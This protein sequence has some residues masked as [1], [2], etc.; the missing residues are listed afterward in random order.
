MLVQPQPAIENFSTGTASEPKLDMTS[1]DF[2]KL[3]SDTG[4]LLVG[5]AGANPNDPYTLQFFPDASTAG[6]TEPTFVPKSRVERVELLQ[7][8]PVQNTPLNMPSLWLV[9][10]HLSPTVTTEKARLD[11]VF[12]E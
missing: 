4:L 5:A 10:L 6:S 8:S 1:A 12:E 3:S 2:V 7:R 9:R 11:T